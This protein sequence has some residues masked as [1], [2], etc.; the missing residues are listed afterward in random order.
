MSVVSLCAAGCLSGPPQFDIELLPHL[1][2]SPQANMQYASLTDGVTFS[3]EATSKAQNDTDT[4]RRQDGL[5]HY[6]IE[7]FSQARGVELIE[8]GWAGGVVLRYARPVLLVP[9]TMKPG[10]THRA[11]AAYDRIV[12]GDVVARG[13]DRYEVTFEGTED[14]QVPAGPFAGTVRLR[15]ELT[16]TEAGTESTYTI[17][18]LYGFGVGLVAARG[19]QAGADGD[20]KPV[21]VAL[22]G[23]QPASE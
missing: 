22:V 5:G 20:A 15:T 18:E 17:T 9:A 12:A 14:V 6:R 3:T 11:E 1:H 2:P 8:R 21:S 16:R 23:I 13:R 10:E 19:Q 7:R 4:I